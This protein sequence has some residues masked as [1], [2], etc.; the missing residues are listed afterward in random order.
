MD[1]ESLGNMEWILEATKRLSFYLIGEKPQ[2]LPAADGDHRIIPPG[3]PAHQQA[4]GF[5]TITNTILISE[6]I[7]DSRIRQVSQLKNSVF[8]LTKLRLL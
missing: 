6:V 5:G 8:R 3:T 1:P 2:R 4:S 7:I